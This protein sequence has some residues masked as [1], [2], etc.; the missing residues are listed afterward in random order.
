VKIVAVLFS[1]I[2]FA[3][4]AGMNY[5]TLLTLFA[6]IIC[7]CIINNPL[8]TDISMLAFRIDMCGIA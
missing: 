8:E 3:S 5:W 7:A 6:Y 1:G 2:L 4:V